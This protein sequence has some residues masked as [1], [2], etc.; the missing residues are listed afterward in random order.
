MQNRVTVFRK[1]KFLVDSAEP[2]RPA[3]V[4]TSRLAF[5][6]SVK[7]TK[8]ALNGRGY[9]SSAKSGAL[10]VSGILSSSTF[11]AHGWLLHSCADSAA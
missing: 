9:R 10:E 6:F 7:Q 11:K 1:E 8:G 4:V 3:G 5:C 2:V